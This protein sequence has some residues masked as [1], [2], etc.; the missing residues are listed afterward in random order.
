MSSW[1]VSASSHL[2]QT[3]LIICE[4]HDVPLVGDNQGRQWSEAPLDGL[5]VCSFE[6]E[7]VKK[8]EQQQ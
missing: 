2:T 1:L 4:L 3:S 8:M 7:S 5:L 6:L